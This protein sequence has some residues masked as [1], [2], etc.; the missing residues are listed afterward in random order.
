[1]TQYDAVADKSTQTDDV[2]VVRLIPTKMK[3]IRADGRI[4]Y[5]TMP[6]LKCES[7]V[8][9]FKEIVGA[10]KAKADS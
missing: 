7:C 6:L 10:N 9:K 1:M 3:L 4:W 8:S 5:E 2:N